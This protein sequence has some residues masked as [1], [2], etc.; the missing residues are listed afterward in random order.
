M[1]RVDAAYLA[2]IV[3]GEGTV[4]LMRNRAN[5]RRC[6]HVSIANTNE[7]LLLWVAHVTGLGRV[8]RRTKRRDTWA[9]GYEW[10]VVGRQALDVLRVVL[11]Y[12]RTGK[13]DRAR[14][15]VDQYV[16]LTVRNGQY[17][18]E[19]SAARDAFE[20]EVLAIRT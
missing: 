12:L 13:R 4:T 18:A 16:S 2:G 17:S 20:A 5:E 19:Q 6:P 8:R 3:D 7:G 15:M 9:D 11:P 10:R 1:A 14:L